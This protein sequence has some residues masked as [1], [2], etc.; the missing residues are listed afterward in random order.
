MVD[1]SYIS[2]LTSQSFTKIMGPWRC[3]CRW[4]TDHAMSLRI[5]SLSSITNVD[6][7]ELNPE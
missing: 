5:C 4:L 6:T 1:G 2:L 3:Y 7:G